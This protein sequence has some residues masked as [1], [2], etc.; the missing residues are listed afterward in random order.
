MKRPLLLA[1]TLVLPCIAHAESPD[2]DPF[3]SP[4]L[5]ADPLPALTPLTRFDLDELRIE[6]VISGVADP[7]AVITLPDGTSV[8]AGRG[9]PIGRHG[10]RIARI[11]SD[12]IVVAETWTAADGPA[13]TRETTLPVEP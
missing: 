4:L 1:L 7:A 6:G 9:A 10:G 12:A 2:R 11:A 5:H 8:V 3:R 13:S